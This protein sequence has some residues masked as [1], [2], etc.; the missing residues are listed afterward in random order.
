M[1]TTMSS[2]SDSAER[3]QSVTNELQTTDTDSGSGSSDVATVTP[4]LWTFPLEDTANTNTAISDTRS[5]SS[6]SSSS[7]QHRYNNNNNNNSRHHHYNKKRTGPQQSPLPFAQQQQ[8]PIIA[9]THHRNSMRR[10]PSDDSVDSTYSTATTNSV[11]STASKISKLPHAVK[12]SLVS[13]KEFV[14]KSTAG[15][16][17]SIAST[18]ALHPP[19]TATMLSP[20]SSALL[21]A[22]GRK[23]P[24]QGAQ[25][26]HHYPSI[27]TDRDSLASRFRRRAPSAMSLSSR[28][29]SKDHDRSGPGD[30]TIVPSVS[31]MTGL[32]ASADQEQR[33][34]EKESKQRRKT[35]DKRSSMFDMAARLLHTKDDRRRRAV[36]QEQSQHIN[37]DQPAIVDDLSSIIDQ[38]T[39]TDGR[40]VG[41][42]LFGV[43]IETSGGFF[44][45]DVPKS[46][47]SSIISGTYSH[48]LF[49]FP[50]KL[51][52]LMPLL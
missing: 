2:M 40:G 31:A 28:F 18:A 15:R 41:T 7:H 37:H 47:A 4:P 35:S 16:R 12:S 33:Q 9:T 52:R 29:S 8:Q 11:F 46:G 42:L 48:W 3:R 19:T 21:A 30:N 10:R 51:E 13:V 6:S 14:T 17:R 1:A 34:H 50:N 39:P 38:D 43:D 32:H 5:R 45:H 24:S 36:Q 23:S 22:T 27:T 25:T 26:I 49:F 44:D 20:G